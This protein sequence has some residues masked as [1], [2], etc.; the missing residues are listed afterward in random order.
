MRWVF[1][2]WAARERAADGLCLSDV[3]DQNVFLVFFGLRQSLFIGCRAHHAFIGVI[4]DPEEDF[5]KAFERY[6][7]DLAAL[8]MPKDHEL[9]DRTNCGVLII[10]RRPVQDV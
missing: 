9:A 4:L 3:V 10:R 8:I 2:R 7:T 1:W 6:A 5:L